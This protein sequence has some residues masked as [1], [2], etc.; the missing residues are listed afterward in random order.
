MCASLEILFYKQIRFAFLQT[1][2]V[3]IK[4][5]GYPMHLKNNIFMWLSM[6]WKLSIQCIE[7]CSYISNSGSGYYWA[8]Y[9]EL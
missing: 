9:T 1:S 5:Q 6:Y 8:G 3:A 7:K 4:N 2:A